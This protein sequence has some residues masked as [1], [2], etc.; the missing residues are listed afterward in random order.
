MTRPT[1]GQE[2]PDLVMASDPRTPP[3]VLHRLTRSRD[4]D[5][6]GAVASNPNTALS[7]L[8]TLARRFPA[9]FT[10]NPV[11]D[12][13][14]LTDADWPNELSATSR[15]RALA[16]TTSVGL[17]WWSVNNGDDDDRLAA[18]T[19]PACPL[20]ILQV[21]MEFGEDAITEV[22]RHH[23]GYS[24]QQPFD[25]SVLHAAASAVAEEDELADLLAAGLLPEWFVSA[26]GLPSDADARRELAGHPWASPMVLRDLLGD[27]DE[28]IRRV[29]SS[30]P[31]A[32]DED[33]RRWEHLRT[34]GVSLSPDDLDIIATTAFGRERSAHLSQLG[35]ATRGACVRDSSWR[36]REAVARNPSLTQGEAGGLAG[37]ADR[38]VRAAAVSNPALPLGAVFALLVDTD[39][40]VRSAAEER[41]ATGETSATEWAV[42]GTVAL[43]V[44]R[45]AP[46]TPLESLLRRGAARSADVSQLSAASIDV[47]SADDDVLVRSALAANP[48]SPPTLLRC[49]AADPDPVVRCRV[50]TRVT[51]E[52]VL[53]ALAGDPS[54]DV[55][56][57]AASNNRLPHW[58][59]LRLAQSPSDDVRSA[60]ASRDDLAADVL[61]GLIG[62]AA[63]DPVTI[64]LVRL[65]GP[66]AIDP[67]VSDGPDRSFEPDEVR[68]V[69]EEHNWAAI[70]ALRSPGFPAPLLSVLRTSPNWRVRQSVAGHQ[71]TSD[72]DLRALAVDAD[73]DVRA[74]VAANPSVAPDTFPSFVTETDEKVRRAL[75]GRPDISVGLLSV[76]L[77]GDDGIRQEALEHPNLPDDS[78]VELDA[79][80]HGT[81]VDVGV[82][83]RFVDTSARR[84]VAAHPLTTADLLHTMAGDASWN[85]REIVARHPS[86]DVD[87]FRVLADDNDRDVRAAVAANHRTPL[88][89]LEDLAEDP[90]PR[91]RR[92][93]MS[94]QTWV[95]IGRLRRA[96]AISRS[97]LRSESAIL[98]VIGLLSDD[99]DAATLRRLRHVRSINWIERFA[100]AV[101]PRTSADV[102]SVL[103]DDANAIVRAGAKGDLQWPRSS[104]GAS[105][106]R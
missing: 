7:D 10:T 68:A 75:V 3:R 52:D 76:H 60:L 18:A 104:N 66:R 84:L 11:L 46:P 70:V 30:N 92:A 26:L 59:A 22:A 28:H 67:S 91:V 50:A 58:L 43:L 95:G 14:T 6:R 89:I 86:C 61:A 77:L 79:L 19:N 97:L 63:E 93:V 41:I 105:V 48:S 39:S 106:R 9:E 37:D 90:D 8:D 16:V 23:V 20:E 51:H 88:G 96:G 5:V 103:A 24:P 54:T 74:A 44:E 25:A 69:L 35:A 27:D 65:I 99:L 13:L 15:H 33:V 72:A 73:N 71:N 85:I 36:V 32:R 101:H 38:D 102:R 82:L 62:R 47:L 29:A 40:R 2:S 57:A 4:R 98:R 78:R 34:D 55:Q 81:P 100:V 87:D 31:N 21:L 56:S 12:W 80:R 94:N 83:R 45:N 53:A 49:L 1:S 17:L 42:A 64:A